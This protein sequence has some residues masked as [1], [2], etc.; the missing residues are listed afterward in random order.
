[1]EQGAY[2]T[3]FMIPQVFL[4]KSL[5]RELSSRG[6]AGIACLIIVYGII[7]VSFFS[8]LLVGVW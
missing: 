7:K 5:I 8:A 4:I 6:L 3:P 1:M 2:M